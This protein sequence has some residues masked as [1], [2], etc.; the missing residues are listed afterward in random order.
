MLAEVSVTCLPHG[1]SMASS[2]QK[3]RRRANV[4]TRPL[5]QGAVL[6][7][8]DSGRCYRLNRVGA[9]IWSML[10][11]P[12]DLGQVCASVAARYGRAVDT[13]EPEI[14]ELV[15]RLTKEQLLEPAA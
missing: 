8:M 7:D 10:E 3:I 6:V 5:P 12:S 9:E 11:S 2:E 15:E 13:I 14:R 4:E 1:S